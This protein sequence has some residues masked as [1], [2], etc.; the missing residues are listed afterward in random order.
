[1]TLELYATFA[2][3]LCTRWQL[4]GGGDVTLHIAL[5]LLPLPPRATI[6]LA[7]D[8]YWSDLVQLFY[9]AYWRKKINQYVNTFETN[10][11]W[12]FMRI[13]ITTCVI[14]HAEL[15]FLKLYKFC[16]LLPSDVTTNS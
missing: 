3:P 9:I 12:A 4:K 15:E 1:M 14:K 8:I 2:T 16:A 6:T 7:G 11:I 10:I 5:H 13:C